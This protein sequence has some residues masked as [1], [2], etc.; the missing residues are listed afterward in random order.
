LSIALSLGRLPHFLA[1]ATAAAVVVVIVVV[2][3]VT[4]SDDETV[5]RCRFDWELPSSCNMLDLGE[6]SDAASQMLFRTSCR[7]WPRHQFVSF[8]LCH[9]FHVALHNIDFL[10]ALSVVFFRQ[11]Q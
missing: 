4:G 5:C 11:R 3:D 8:E 10:Y 2:F 6:K 9:V 7:L 1:I